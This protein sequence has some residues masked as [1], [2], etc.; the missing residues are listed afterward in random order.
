MIQ[1]DRA[2]WKYIV[3][4]ILTCGIYGYYFIYKLAMDVNVMCADDGKKTS[5]LV[6]F[7]LL[8]FLTCGIYAWFWYYSL[9]N[10]LQENASRYGLN[11]PEN[12]T[13][14]LLWFLLGSLLCGIGSFVAVHILIKNTNAM[15]RA[16]NGQNGY[17]Q[18][19]N[20][21][22]E[23]VGLQQRKSSPAP[24]ISSA[25]A[26]KQEFSATAQS[27]GGYCDNQT[28][29]LSQNTMPKE[30]RGILYFVHTQQSV[31]I[32]RD[33]F[34]IGKNAGMV[35][36]VIA[37]DSSVSRQHAVIIRRNGQFFLSDLGSTNGTFI[38]DNRISGMVQLQ[39]GDNIRFADAICV[40]NELNG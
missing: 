6:P 25:P 21:A 24:Q 11:F 20:A 7:I 22:T 13:T 8:S 3:F 10:R 30:N 16:Y 23:A 40:F 15:A 17:A 35:D 28:T 4:G 31:T 9:G 29:I 1:E 33:E 27:I 18:P 39:D 2:L 14:V 12:G 26:T 38:N 19:V 34:R 37:N 32:D 5:G 36:Y